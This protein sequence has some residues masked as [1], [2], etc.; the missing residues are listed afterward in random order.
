MYTFVTFI[1]LS[2]AYYGHRNVDKYFWNR[3]CRN[4]VRIVRAYVSLRIFIDELS[5]LTETRRWQIVI[6]FKIIS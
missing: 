4:Y 2:K 1:Y 6:A 3:S 5:A